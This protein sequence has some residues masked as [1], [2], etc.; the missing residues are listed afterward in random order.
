MLN[1]SRKGMAVKGRAAVLLN[2]KFKSLQLQALL[3]YIF[4]L[5]AVS[6]I[7]GVCFWIRNI[8]DS[9]DISKTV[10]D[11]AWTIHRLFLIQPH[12]KAN[13]VAFLNILNTST[14]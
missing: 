1:I 8:I 4:R 12:Q 6:A 2:T 7:Y 14:Y 11:I 13:Y 9:T 10:L 5:L 3:L